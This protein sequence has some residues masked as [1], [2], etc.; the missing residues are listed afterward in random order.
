M[1]KS[2]ALKN[3]FNEELAHHLSE[4]IVPHYPSFQ[5]E[6]F[7]HSV[8]QQVSPLQ[9]KARVAVISQALK[10]QLPNRYPDALAILMNILGPENKTEEGMFT[11]GYF[12]MP[13]AHFVETY[14]LSHYHLSMQALYEITKRHTAEYA[15]RPYLAHDPDQTLKI[16][17]KW[18]NDSN[19]H[20]RRLVS[21]GTRPRLPWAKKI[22]VLKGEIPY[23]FQLL[24]PLLNDPSPYV[25]KSVA[26]H[27]NDLTKSHPEQ[28]LSWIQHVMT[29]S[30]DYNNWVIQQ[31]LRTLKKQGDGRALNILNDLK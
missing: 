19:S 29:G 24:K 20:V 11:N 12:L 4:L 6:A 22:D 26:N 3:Y 18:L 31:G 2:V 25:R 17:T 23:H 27:I 15:I 10:K 9:L 7:I 21:E 30:I 8:E 16:L 1:T 14:G 5:S 28:T 13:L